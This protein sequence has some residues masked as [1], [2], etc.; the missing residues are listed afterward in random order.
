[1][2]EARRMPARIQRRRARG[3]VAPAGAVYVGRPTRW[4]NPFRTEAYAVA[5]HAVQDY[6]A[7]LNG[8]LDAAGTRPTREEI[9]RELGGKDL[10]CWCALGQPCHADVLLE[11]ANKENQP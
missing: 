9:I 5:S 8:E 7:W 3:W 4:G 1:M 2:T 11:I 6:R 10:M